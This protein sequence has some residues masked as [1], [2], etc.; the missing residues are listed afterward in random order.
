[1]YH[2]KPLILFKNPRFITIHNNV[3]SYSIFYWKTLGRLK[4]VKIK[5]HLIKVWNHFLNYPY[6]LFWKYLHVSQ[7]C[8]RLVRLRVGLQMNKGNISSFPFFDDPRLEKK[9]IQVTSRHHCQW[10]WWGFKPVP[11]QKGATEGPHWLFG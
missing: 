8:V 9:K 11:F 4:V 3:D 7:G 5:N 1:M 10:V 6:L 2:S